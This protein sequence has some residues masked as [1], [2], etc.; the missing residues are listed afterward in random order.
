MGTLP[1]PPPLAGYV[2]F[3]EEMGSRPLGFTLDS[4][5][6]SEFLAWGSVLPA[7]QGKALGHLPGGGL[8]E[9]GGKGKGT[10]FQGKR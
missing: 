6:A 8:G 10:D 5:S 2:S 9:D 3:P 7:C 1:G 4:P